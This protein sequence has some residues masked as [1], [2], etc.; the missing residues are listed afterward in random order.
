MVQAEPR[1]MRQLLYYPSLHRVLAGRN[2]RADDSKMRYQGDIDKGI[3]YDKL[4]ADLTG[5]RS[6][7]LKHCRHSGNQLLF[8]LGC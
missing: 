7:S 5:R 4:V 3:A 2:K 1:K 6:F 8:L